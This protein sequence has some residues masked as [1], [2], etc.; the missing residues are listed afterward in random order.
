MFYFSP[1][2]PYTAG[3]YRTL[4]IYMCSQEQKEIFFIVSYYYFY[5]SPLTK[6][7]FGHQGPNGQML[8]YSQLPCLHVLHVCNCQTY[9]PHRL[10]S[11]RSYGKKKTYIT[12]KN[13]R[14]RRFHNCHS[15]AVSLMHKIMARKPI[16]KRLV[17]GEQLWG[18]F[19]SFLLPVI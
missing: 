8:K 5:M 9:S 1:K 4:H 2:V 3:N 10:C 19:Q 7:H 17:I 15:T 11:R 13:I 6:Q 12:V 18:L 16:E 14:Q